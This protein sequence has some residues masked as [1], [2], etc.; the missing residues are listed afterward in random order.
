MMI[1]YVN[2]NNRYV[3]FYASNLRATEGNFH[4]RKWKVENDEVLKDRVS[5]TI[6]L[7]LRGTLEERQKKLDEICE[8]FE[9]DVANK[10]HGKM[11]YGDYYLECYVISSDTHISST[12]V[13]RSD[14]ELEIYSCRE[15][16]IK[17]NV[18]SF[19]GANIEPTPQTDNNKVY[20][21]TYLY[22]YGKSVGNK[23]FT[24]EVLKDSDFKMIV[25]GQV[26]NPQITINNHLYNVEVSL[27]S[28]EY[29]V[30][31]SE[32]KKIY[33]VLND[34]TQVNCFD[35]RNFESYIFESIKKGVNTVNWSGGFSF[36]LTVY[37]ERSEPRWQ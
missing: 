28:D 18:F 20:P 8:I 26:N 32:R 15:Y 14:V 16:W 33:K 35:K 1:R 34:G 3:D 11:Y 21:Y 37:E 7:T 19:A 29:L 17:D 36:D 2:S 4:I 22:N 9:T 24:L 31:D 6:T 23:K 25:Y 13:S 10:K 30:I 12:L 5:Y 27:Y